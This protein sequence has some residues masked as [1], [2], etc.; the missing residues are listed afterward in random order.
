M[1]IMLLLTFLLLL[2]NLNGADSNEDM[3]IVVTALHKPAIEL[4]LR[5]K[6]VRSRVI[7]YPITYRKEMFYEKAVEEGLKAYLLGKDEEGS[8]ED[9]EVHTFVERKEAVSLYKELTSENGKRDHKRISFSRAHID[10]VR[11]QMLEEIEAIKEA[12]EAQAAKEAEAAKPLEK[13]AVIRAIDDI[14]D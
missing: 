7:C 12:E 8:V 5:G 3:Y 6:A 14:Y 9:V 13:V 4:T 10:K 1:R 2:G 11:K